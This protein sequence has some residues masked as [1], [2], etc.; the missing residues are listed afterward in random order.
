MSSYK[1]TILDGVP[2]LGDVPMLGEIPLLGERATWEER[3]ENLL[4]Q[5][6]PLAAKF[7]AGANSPAAAAGAAFAAI[8][9]PA[10][11]SAR[12]L[13]IEVVATTATASDIGLA[14]TTARGTA[15]TTM[16]GQ[17]LDALTGAS[18]VQFDTA[19]SAQPTIAATNLKR[20]LLNAAGNGIVWSWDDTDPLFVSAAAGLCLVNRGGAAAGIQSV[21]FEWDEG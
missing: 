17:A 14:R 15:T 3:W 1:A 2:V 10:A 18:T 13:R 5:G 9:T 16:V 21:S 6:V 11:R 12:V 7:D 4:E 19:W 20:I 8:W